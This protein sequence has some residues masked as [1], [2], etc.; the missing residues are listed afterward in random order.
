MPEELFKT[1]PKEVLDYFDR[2][3]SVP[4]FD[5]RDISSREHALAWTAAKTSG[6]DVIEDIRAAVREAVNYKPYEQFAAELEETLRAKGWWGR[7]IVTDPFTGKDSIVQLGSPRRLRT[8][9]WGNVASA[10]AAGEWART[11]ATRDVL[12][13][14]EYLISLSERK[15]PEH[16]GWVGTTLPVDDSW[17]LTHYPPNGWHCKCRVRQMSAPEANRKPAEKRIRP[18]IDYVD[19]KNKRTGEIEKVPLGV[20]PGWGHN[21]GMLRDRTL[22]RGLNAALDRMPEPA[23]RA[24]VQ[25]LARHPLAEYVTSGR[26]SRDNH[27]PVAVLPETIGRTIGADTTIVR[28]SGEIGI[29]A[30]RV[31]ASGNLHHNESDFATYAHVQDAVD[32]GL[33]VQE[34][35]RKL[36]VDL[37][38]DDGLYWRASLTATQDGSE[39][40]LSTWYKI[41]ERRHR[42][43]LHRKWRDSDQTV[44][45]IREGE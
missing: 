13:Y 34:G 5:W 29:K 27:A 8:I 22:S 4:T 35:A 31:G 33:V 26:A 9:Y 16:M 42:R 10:Q 20:D 17:W 38:D 40:F 24:A 12:P 7:K 28:M 41:S 45:V 15:R 43:L 21:P 6:F 2:R 19:W 36:L 11:W 30:T 18:S 32:R 14:L 1:A 23:R 39:I 37:R 3:P 25:Q 44:R